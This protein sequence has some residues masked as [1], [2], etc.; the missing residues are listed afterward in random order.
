MLTHTFPL[1]KWRDAF[2]AV[3]DQGSSGALK[4][5]FDLRDGTGDD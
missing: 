1:E 5:A 2:A 4:V 3:A